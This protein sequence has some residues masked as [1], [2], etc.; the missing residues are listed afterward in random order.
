[1]Q[2]AA[3]HLRPKADSHVMCHRKTDKTDLTDLNGFFAKIRL[4]LLD[5]FNLLFNHA[6]SG[7]TW[8]TLARP[9]L[10]SAGVGCCRKPHPRSVPRRTALLLN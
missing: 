8:K 5:P 4:N 3:K 9:T 1:M 10:H 6:T 7:S 2:S